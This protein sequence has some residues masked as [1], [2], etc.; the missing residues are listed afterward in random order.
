MKMEQRVKIK[1][2]ETLAEFAIAFPIQNSS[3]D[4]HEILILSQVPFAWEDLL[5]LP[6]PAHIFLFASYLS[7]SASFKILLHLMY[8]WFVQFFV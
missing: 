7:V 2:D 4:L 8:L 6:P 5:M 1:A 3:A